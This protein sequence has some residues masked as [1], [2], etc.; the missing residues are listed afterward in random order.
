MGDQGLYIATGKGSRACD[1]GFHFTALLA[2]TLNTR[3]GRFFVKS[4]GLRF[5]L[6]SSLQQPHQPT[7]NEVALPQEHYTR[8]HFTTLRRPRCRR[9]S[10]GT[11]S[12]AGGVVVCCPSSP[13]TAH[14]DIQPR[15]DENSTNCLLATASTSRRACRY[16]R[17]Q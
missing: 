3:R 4:S 8:A 14:R 11:K 13:V 2:P 16:T 17:K 9:R 15:H 1:A 6:I 5:T 10:L 12:T 7:D